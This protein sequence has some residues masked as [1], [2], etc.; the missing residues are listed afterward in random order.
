MKIIHIPLIILLLT[1][2]S[3]T[4]AQNSLSGKITVGN[5]NTPLGMVSVYIPE[6]KRGAISDNS[7]AFSFSNL[8]KTTF[9]LQL[10]IPGYKTQVK[11]IDLRKTTSVEV[12]M[13]TSPTELEE[14]LVTSSNTKLP[15][16][17]PFS[18]SSISQ[19]EL[20]K[21][22]SLSVAGNLSAQ[23]GIDR[24]S[25]GNGIG[26]PVIR[27]LSFNQIMLY[28]QGTR[29]EN[30]QWDDH[31]D[32]GLTDIGLD[33][34]ELV[35]GPAA[36]IYGADA[37]GGALI[38]NDEKP[39][40]A[41]TTLGSCNLGFNTNTL[42]LTG[43]LGIRGTYNNGFFYGVRVGGASHT[44]YVQGE[45]DEANKSG[46][47]EEFAANS[48]FM[49]V[50]ARMNA[51]VSKKWGVS[52][53]SYTFQKQLTGIVENESDTA[54]AGGEEEQRDRGMEAPYQDVTSHIISVE[55]TFFTGKSKLNVNAAYQL[56]DRK[57]FEPLANKQKEMAI[58]LK[59]N[60][61]T[62]DVKWSSNAGKDFGMTFGTQGTF[63]SNANSGLEALVP[64]AG[65]R[66][67]AGYALFRYDHKK[68]N[69]LGGVR[70]DMRHIEAE[71]Y[72]KNAGVEEDSFILLHA[73]DTI[74]KPE[75]DFEKN[76]IP[77][78]FSLGAAW[79]PAR[80]VTIKLN[81]ATGFTAPNY[82]QL[83]TF[84][85][86]EGT[87]RFER[88]NMGLK[89]E[90]NIEGDLGV[91]WENKF[92]SLN[93]GGY[94]N[95][96]RDYIYIANTGDSIVRITPDVRDTLPVYD[97]RQGNAT[98]M[99][100]EFG[101]DIHPHSVRWLD[102]KATYAFIKG[103]LGSGGNLPYIP[104]NK[105]IGEVRLTKDKIWKLHDNYLSVVVSNYAMRKDVA[106]YELSSKGYTLL[107]IFAGA[108]FNLGKQRPN[109][110]LYCTNLLNTGYYN[111][112]SLVKYIGIR[113]MGRNFGIR[114]TVPFAFA[115][116]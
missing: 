76:Y 50:V 29:I 75:T 105:L 47:T 36:L 58:G 12:E 44:S 32:L 34:I 30:Q 43:D 70:I 39:A 42:G 77:V 83:G 98:I 67:L 57:E 14:V 101:L 109:F 110:T 20:R 23:P 116:K 8:P 102:V 88:G 84:G 97:Y 63:L 11:T 79:H 69:L 2:F 80:E 5:G 92:L 61:I 54:K 103:T 33:N 45:G 26:K 10:S 37:L 60:V 40:P 17:I 90:Q 111:Q 81:G 6:L 73:K 94:V 55:N 89:V 24:I 53:L 19:S 4:F 112:L 22:G 59:L 87:Y 27:G 31:H 96:I 95:S 9:G 35:R 13:E 62:Y 41:G 72:E 68:F 38:F 56:N 93:A 71:S 18:A 85:K 78:S 106:A 49:N 107:D 52:K 7:G 66:D 100:A 99:G 25:L 82:A 91:I 86:H 65:E 1:L 3:N 104:S 21:S 46:E 115:R 64:N 48:K 16:N 74:K 15:D 114:L 108:S 113:E 51:G 28:G